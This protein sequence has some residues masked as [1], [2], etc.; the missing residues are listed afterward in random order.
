MTNNASFFLCLSFLVDTTP[1]TIEGCPPDINE[2]IELGSPDPAVVWIEPIATDLSPVMTLSQ[3]NQP[4]MTFPVGTTTVT[5]I[6]ADS[7]GNTAVCSFDVIVE[8]SKD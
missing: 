4:G 8:T 7:S 2:V 1:P 3:S 6:F 5:Y